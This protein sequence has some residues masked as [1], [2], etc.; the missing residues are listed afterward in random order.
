MPDELIGSSTSTPPLIE[1]TDDDGDGW[2]D[3]D[4]ILCGSNPKRASDRPAD[5]DL[6]MICDTQDDD[7]DGDGWLNE[8]ESGI[9]G[10]N[11]LDAAVTP[12][13]IDGDMVCDQIDSDIDGDG[14]SNED[15]NKTACGSTNI[16]DPNDTPSDEDLSLIHI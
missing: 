5:M 16:Y 7:I 6:D 8:V 11:A 12:S 4:E 14:W 1:D 15:E 9:C 2:E 13:D 10:G 3:L